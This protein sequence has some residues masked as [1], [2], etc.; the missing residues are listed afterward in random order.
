MPTLRSLL[1]PPINVVG[2]PRN[3]FA[4][5]NSTTSSTQPTNKAEAPAPE[6][7]TVCMSLEE[8]L[9]PGL[10][11]Q[12]SSPLGRG[13]SAVLS[14][15]LHFCLW[16]DTLTKKRFLKPP[17]NQDGDKPASPCDG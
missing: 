1:E 14:H 8:A 15:L 2:L 6:D 7:S 12:P 11:V 16:G 10:W 13:K 17:H 4:I 9:S 3:M 5:Q